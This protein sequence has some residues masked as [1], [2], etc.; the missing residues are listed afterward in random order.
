[1]KIDVEFTVKSI[2]KGS[3]E[4]IIIVNTNDTSLIVQ[5]S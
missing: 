4:R 2:Q 3:A 5:A 1:M